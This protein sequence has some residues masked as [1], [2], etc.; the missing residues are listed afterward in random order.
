MSNLNRDHNN[1][2]SYRNKSHFWTDLEVK[3]LLD[4]LLRSGQKILSY[5]TP[6][7][8][9]HKEYFTYKKLFIATIRYRVFE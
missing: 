4:R 5:S 6:R 7:R 3:T 8:I 9:L 1:N 2:V